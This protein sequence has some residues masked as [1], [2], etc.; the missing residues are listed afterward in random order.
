MMESAFR[1]CRTCGV[2]FEGDIEDICPHCVSDGLWRELQSFQSR[3]TELLEDFP[4]ACL[5][6]DCCPTVRSRLQAW[7]VLSSQLLDDIPTAWL[8]VDLC[9]T[10]RGRLQA[11]TVLSSQLLTDLNDYLRPSDSCLP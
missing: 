7:T 8:M 5:M 6:V 3:L 11:W 1:R 10:V 4:T 2:R 9:P